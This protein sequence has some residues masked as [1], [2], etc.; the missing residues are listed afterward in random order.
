M[1][2]RNSLI[3]LS[4]VLVLGACASTQKQVGASTQNQA[5]ASTQ[6]QSD[7]QAHPLGNTAPVISAPV[8]ELVSPAA[9][10]A[11]TKSL[12]DLVASPAAQQLVQATMPYQ[13]MLAMTKAMQDA[14]SPWMG[15]AKSCSA[16]PTALR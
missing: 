10:P 15:S 2:I 3:G 16:S 11:S 12:P 8:A 1:F 14:M 13:C 6:N 4:T 7:N 5:D 9:E